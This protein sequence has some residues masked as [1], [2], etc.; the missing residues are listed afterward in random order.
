MQTENP[1]FIPAFSFVLEKAAKSAENAVISTLLMH[2][3]YG[4][5]HLRHKRFMF[6]FTSES[7]YTLG[8]SKKIA[9]IGS[10]GE[11]GG[12]PSLGHSTVLCYQRNY[13]ECR[14]CNPRFRHAFINIHFPVLCA[15]TI[16]NSSIQ[17]LF[18]VLSELLK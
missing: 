9:H 14:I 2:Q 11:T 3:S 1:C 13:S 7:E 12:L 16:S 17:K 8:S 15:P 4:L 6:A 10:H 18:Q 5:Q